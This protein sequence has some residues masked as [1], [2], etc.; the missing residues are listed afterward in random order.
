MA[1]VGLKMMQTMLQG[2]VLGELV[3]GFNNQ[4]EDV[5]KSAKVR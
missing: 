4:Q 3:P 1:R 5:H 2:R